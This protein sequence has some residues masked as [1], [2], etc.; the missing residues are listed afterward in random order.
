MGL[1]KCPKCDGT[2]SKYGHYDYVG[3]LLDLFSGEKDDKCPLC[4]GTGYVDDGTI[5]VRGRH[6]VHWYDE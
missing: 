1:R 5:E 4:R 3:A 6:E 2:G